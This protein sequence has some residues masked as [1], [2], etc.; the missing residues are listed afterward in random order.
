MSEQCP[1][2]CHLVADDA[3]KCGWYGCINRCPDY[4]PNLYDPA[5]GR[6]AQSM[7]MQG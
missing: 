5:A 6:L 1:C 7:E 4:N 2:H 3:D